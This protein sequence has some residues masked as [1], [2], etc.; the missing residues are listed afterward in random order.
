MPFGVHCTHAD[1]GIFHKEKQMNASSS[2][3]ITYRYVVVDSQ[4]GQDLVVHPHLEPALADAELHHAAHIRREV[5]VVEGN[6]RVTRLA[7][8]TVPQH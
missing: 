3:P 1:H 4:T 7:T 6:L 8:L 5:T 2:V